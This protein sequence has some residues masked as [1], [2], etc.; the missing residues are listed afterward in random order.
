MKAG[1]LFLQNEPL[2][3]EQLGQHLQPLGAS[4]PDTEVHLRADASVPYGRVIE[5]M[6]M[7]QKAG[8]TRIGFMTEADAPEKN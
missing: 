5:V 2:S 3:L 7:A 8:L 6:G 1:Q 4:Q